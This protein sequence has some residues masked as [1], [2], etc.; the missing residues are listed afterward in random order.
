MPPVKEKGTQGA[1]ATQPTRC[2]HND[3]SP[4]KDKKETVR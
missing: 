3:I 4:P 2:P 1:I